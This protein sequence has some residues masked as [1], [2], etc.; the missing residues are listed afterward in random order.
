M[1]ISTERLKDIEAIADKDIDYSDIPETD[2]SFW[3]KAT[4]RMPESAAGLYV[5]LDPDV[6]RWLRQSGPA[7]Q[8]QINAILRSYMESHPS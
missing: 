6:L 1:T 7:W 4:A 8:S 3:L 5:C 2:E